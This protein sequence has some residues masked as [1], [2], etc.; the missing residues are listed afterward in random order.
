MRNPGGYLQISCDGVVHERDSFTCNHCN[1]VSFV[2][3][4]QDPADLGGLCKTC[5]GLICS[6]CVGQECRTLMAR[7]EAAEASYHA[8][9]SYGL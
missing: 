7:I 9:R 6:A 3:P 1:R 8:R 5:M 2:K 4:K